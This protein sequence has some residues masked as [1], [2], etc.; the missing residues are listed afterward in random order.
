ML[1][2]L[3]QKVCSTLVVLIG[4]KLDA[5]HVTGGTLLSR[6][7]KS[8]YDMLSSVFTEHKWDPWKFASAPK[9]CWTDISNCR[10]FLENFAKMHDIRKLEDWYRI[11]S[12]DIIGGG[13]K[14]M[15]KLYLVRTN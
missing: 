15:W 5:S 11:T 13:G 2:L 12:R 10:A 1:I 7:S 8:L 4:H 6:Y 3:H 14:Y 9:N